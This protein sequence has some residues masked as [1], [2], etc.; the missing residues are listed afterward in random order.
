MPRTRSAFVQNRFSSFRRLHRVTIIFHSSEVNSRQFF[1]KLYNSF[2]RDTHCYL[3]LSFR[4]ELCR[5]GDL[6]N[7]PA[8]NYTLFD[9]AAAVKS[10]REAKSAEECADTLIKDEET[11]APETPAVESSI[12]VWNKII[13]SNQ[14]FGSIFS[15]LYLLCFWNRKRKKM[16]LLRTSFNPQKM[17]PVPWIMRCPSINKCIVSVILCMLSRRKEE[18]NGWFS[19]FKDCGWTKITSKW[20]TVIITTDRVKHIMWLRENFWKRWVWLA[21]SEFLKILFLP[22]KNFPDNM[23]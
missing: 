5:N 4:D 3:S 23:K 14:F 10:V 6:L 12:K 7:S 1:L 15:S 18:W 16:V 11:E 20:C 8:L 17:P 19:T 9:L 13:F 2:W 22:S 21:F